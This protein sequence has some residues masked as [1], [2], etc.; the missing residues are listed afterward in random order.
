MV[1][2]DKKNSPQFEA[3]ASSY[4]ADGFRDF[5]A[6]LTE[7]KDSSLRLF[8]PNP[9]VAIDHGPIRA[10]QKERRLG[11]RGLLHWLLQ[12]LAGHP[13]DYF[14]FGVMSCRTF[15]R[16]IEWTP[17]E[18]ARFYGFDTFEGL[19][20]P[21]VGARENGSLRMG[22][23]AGELKAAYPPAV[24]DKRAVLFKG[25]F[26]ETLPDALQ[27][28]FPS[29][30]QAHRPMILNVDSDLYSSALY[31]LTSM[32]TLHRTGDYVYFD[33][34][35]DTLNEFAAFNDYVRA[36]GTKSWFKPVARAYDG[37]LFRIEIPGST[38]A[39]VEAIERRT[40]HFLERMK[41]YARARA[42]LFMPNDPGRP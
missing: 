6:F 41:A 35:F 3:H 13:I 10:T 1:A 30:R 25:L 40:T 15:N 34:F 26:Q 7:T 11:K 5:E 22:R 27:T 33:E 37:M 24:Y 38:R 42:S 19:P 39:P 8:E 9:A 2:I 32:H 20:Q 17:S 29:G 31:V 36:Y 28:A 14:E 23:E 12:S 4:F 18:D 16:A 21:W